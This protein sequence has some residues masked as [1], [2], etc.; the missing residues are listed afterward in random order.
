M[1]ALNPTLRSLSLKVECSRFRS[2]SL[3]KKINYIC[4][5]LK[6]A[7]CICPWRYIGNATETLRGQLVTLTT[8]DTVIDALITLMDSPAGRETEITI[9]PPSARYIRNLLGIPIPPFLLCPYHLSRLYIPECGKCINFLL[10]V[11]A[12]SFTQ[13]DTAWNTFLRAPP[14]IKSVEP[15]HDRDRNTK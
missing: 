11:M 4:V 10:P 5:L 9:I 1:F 15:A 2:F 12:D 13:V 14:S 3:M 6:M 7:T 8:L